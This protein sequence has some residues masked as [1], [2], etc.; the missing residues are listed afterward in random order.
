M[1]RMMVLAVL[2]AAPVFAAQAEESVAPLPAMNFTSSLAADQ[3]YGLVKENPAFGSLEKNLVGSPIQL[4]ITHTLQPTAGGMA[5]GLLSAIWTGGT[6]GLL[7]MV[8]NNDLVLHYE[9]LVNG[10]SLV[11]YSF[12][13]NFTRAVNIWKQDDPTYGLGDQGLAWARTTATDFAAQAAR[14]AEMASLARE[15]AYFFGE[16]ASKP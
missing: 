16:A 10:K 6:L 14:S 13:R 11:S 15:Y 2:S 8:T 1:K 4:R 12:Q 7:P 5:T 3:L 9:V